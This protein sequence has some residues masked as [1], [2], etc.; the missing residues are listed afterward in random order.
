MAT[1]Y[2][3]SVMFAPIC[4]HFLDNTKHKRLAIMAAF[5]ITASTYASLTQFDSFA[6]VVMT[7]I[8]QSAISG[9]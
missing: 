9:M 2:I 7:L 3:V 4:G 8:V 6:A 5:L 1:Q